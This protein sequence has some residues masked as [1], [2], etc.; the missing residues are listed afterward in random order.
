[1]RQSLGG[2]AGLASENLELSLGRRHRL[3]GSKAWEE[4]GQTESFSVLHQARSH[5][6]QRQ[7]SVLAFSKLHHISPSQWEE[8]QSEKNKAVLK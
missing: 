7:L 1:M 6:G 4:M 3:A 5:R 8:H 2:F